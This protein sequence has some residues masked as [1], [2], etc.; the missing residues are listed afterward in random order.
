MLDG[1]SRIDRLVGRASELGME[2]LAITD[3]GGMYGAI[4]FYRTARTAGIRPI[5]GCEMYVARDSRH[6]RNPNDKSPYHHLTVLSKNTVGYRNLV[7][8]VSKSHLEGFY[9]KPRVDR[10]LLE[11]HHDGLIVLSGCISGEVPDLI[12][13]GRTEDAKRS[14]LWYRELFDDYYIELMEH[15]GIENLPEIKRGLVSLSR[16]TGIPLVATNDSHYVSREDAPLQDILICIHTNTNVQDERR[17][18]MVADT[19]YLRSVDE[20]R[21]SVV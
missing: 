13:Q 7:K 20:D 6:I 5:I 3:H 15:G 2:S 17:L 11:E 21:K 9:Y 4:D 1:L 19:Y 14:A 16:E 10:E 8:L 12:A 18:K